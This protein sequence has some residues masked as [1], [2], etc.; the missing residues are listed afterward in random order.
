MIFAK[1]WQ[2]FFTNDISAQL[3]RI[4]IQDIEHYRTGI[5]ERLDFI[6]DDD[7]KSSLTAIRLKLNELFSAILTLSK[8]LD[9]ALAELPA[10]T[11]LKN[12]ILNLI[13]T[14]LAPAL[15]TFIAYLKA[16]E[17]HSYLDHSFLS[18]WKILNR[19]LTDAK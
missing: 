7:N 3:G 10:E 8:A 16:A 11:S 6:R 5:K 19:Q 1:N 17:D 18:P 2:I 9:E 14:K 4:A 15:K 13:R 12:S